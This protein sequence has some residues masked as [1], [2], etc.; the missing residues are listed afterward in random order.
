VRLFHSQLDSEQYSAI[1]QAADVKMQNATSESD[2]EKYLEAVH[3]K[4]G[5]FQNSTLRSWGVVLRGDQGATVKLVYDTS[6]TRGDGTEQFVW[7]I[8]DHHANLDSYRIS[9]RVLVTK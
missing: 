2:L 9:S 3:Q 8:K 4:L 6:F 5:A 1:Y 7:Q